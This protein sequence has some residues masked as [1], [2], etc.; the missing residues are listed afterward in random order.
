MWRGT[1]R[2]LSVL[3]VAAVFAALGAGAAFANHLNPGDAPP[4]VA[5]ITITGNNPKCT[6]DVA[7]L[8]YD[9]E[10][11]YDTVGTYT[12]GQV[13]V[14]GDDTWQIEVTS[15][16]SDGKILTLDWATDL[17]PDAVQAVIMRPARLITTCTSTRRASNATAVLRHKGRA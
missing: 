17:P 8:G 4:D 11:K 14:A 5:P 12:V 9:N 6:D 16:D 10:A 1:A 2:A 7:N 3:V 13:I 15:I